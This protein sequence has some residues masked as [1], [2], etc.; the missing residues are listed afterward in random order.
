MKLFVGN[1]D[2]KVKAEGLTALFSKF[3]P[4]TSSYVINDKKTGE[5]KGFGFVIMEDERQAQAAIKALHGLDIQG[6]NLIVSVSKESEGKSKP[7][8]T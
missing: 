4:V 8:K 3:G 1:F 5:P 7:A 2:P 6:R